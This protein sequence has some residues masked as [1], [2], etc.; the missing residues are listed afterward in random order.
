V[1]MRGALKACKIHLARAAILEQELGASR[2]RMADSCYHCG[3]DHPIIMLRSLCKEFWSSSL[4]K[5]P[6]GCHFLLL[7]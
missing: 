5:L 6:N 2:V 3:S 4:A 1:A 7:A